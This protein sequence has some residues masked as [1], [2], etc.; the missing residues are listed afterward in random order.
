MATT[1]NN[2]TPKPAAKKTVAKPATKA[3]AKPL[4]KKAVAP[5]KG[6]GILGA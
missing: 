3:A 2:I 6:R 5:T 1:S 4:I